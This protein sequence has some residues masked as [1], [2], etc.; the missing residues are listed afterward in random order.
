MTY[1]TNNDIVVLD[2]LCDSPSDGIRWKSD[3]SITGKNS[4]VRGNQLENPGHL[5]HH[6]RDARHRPPRS[7]RLR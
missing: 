7:L 1:V 3:K 6:P 4:L 5:G 2:R